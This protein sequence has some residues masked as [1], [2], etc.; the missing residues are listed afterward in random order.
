MAEVTDC[1][2]KDV[3]SNYRH[4]GYIHFFWEMYKPPYAHQL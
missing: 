3:S 4:G 1:G 2:L